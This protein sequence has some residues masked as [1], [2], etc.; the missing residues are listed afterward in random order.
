MCGS[1][2]DITSCTEMYSTVFSTREKVAL[3]LRVKR[4]SAD[5][6]VLNGL[7]GRFAPWK[8]AESVECTPPLQ[9]CYLSLLC[10]QKLDVNVCRGRT[11]PQAVGFTSSHW[12][13]PFRTT[14]SFIDTELSLTVKPGSMHMQH[15]QVTLKRVILFLLTVA[16]RGKIDQSRPHM[17]RVPGSSRTIL[18]HITKNPSQ[19]FWIQIQR[20]SKS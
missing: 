9:F 13:D 8:P 7:L 17:A 15:I 10:G 11:Q 16:L 14:H 19:K 6:I 2:S 12:G 3:K 4:Y 20:N 18:I 1:C 5:N